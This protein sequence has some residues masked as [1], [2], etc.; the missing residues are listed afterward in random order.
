M[1]QSAGAWNSSLPKSEQQAYKQIIPVARVKIND[2][3][4]DAISFG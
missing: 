1:A 2:I 3:I 4:L